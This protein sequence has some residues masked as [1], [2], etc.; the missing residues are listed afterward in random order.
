MQPEIS[1]FSWVMRYVTKV[2]SNDIGILA[3]IAYVKIKHAVWLW[4]SCFVFLKCEIK[5]SYLTS[6]CRSC[7]KIRYEEQ[8][9]VLI[10]ESSA[11]LRILTAHTRKFALLTWL[12]RT[13][14]NINRVSLCI[15]Y[16]FAALKS[17]FR[18]IPPFV[19]LSLAVIS[20][21]VYVLYFQ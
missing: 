1:I 20:N 13:I 10:R 19:I 11:S 6:A 9:P 15:I 14:Q 12:W 16:V 2:I 8:R 18:Y 5:I 3:N 17:G 21:T 7:M 4:K